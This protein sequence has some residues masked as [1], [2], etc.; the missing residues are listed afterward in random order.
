M[1]DVMK[2]KRQLRRDN[3]DLRADVA[4]RATRE[5]ALSERCAKNG[6]DLEELQ[7]LYDGVTRTLGTMDSD[8]VTALKRIITGLEGENR[9]LKRHLA[10]VPAVAEMSRKLAARDETLREMS[11][12]LEVAREALRLAGEAPSWNP[13]GRDEAD[14]ERGVQVEVAP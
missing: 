9:A 6:N 3:R 1:P 10:D 8:E 11:E 12:Q 7:K 13:A 5:T 4:R 2:S 14:A